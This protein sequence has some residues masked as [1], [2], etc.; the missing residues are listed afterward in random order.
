MKKLLLILLCVPFIFSCVNNNHK[1]DFDDPLSIVNTLI[2]VANSNDSNDFKIL[3]SLCHPDFGDGDTKSMCA[4]S[5]KF[6]SGIA[7]NRISREGFMISFRDAKVNGKVRYYVEEYYKMECAIVPILFG[8]N[9][10]RKEEV[11]LI[12]KDGNWY[13]FSI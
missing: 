8:P 13:L 6:Q 2:Y 3:S 1:V 9:A 5:D 4:L 11:H 7:G 12:K 10:S